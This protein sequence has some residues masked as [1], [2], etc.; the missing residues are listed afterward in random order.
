MYRFI[1]PKNYLHQVLKTL[2]FPNGN[3][4]AMFDKQTFLLRKALNAKKIPSEL[5]GNVGP[6]DGVWINNLALKEIGYKEDPVQTFADGTTNEG[7]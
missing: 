3:R 1:F 5:D 2:K 7:I 4:Y 6:F